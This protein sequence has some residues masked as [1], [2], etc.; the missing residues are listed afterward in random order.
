VR[1]PADDETPY[2]PWHY[3]A[4]G[5]ADGIS[6]IA[7]CGTQVDDVLVCEQSEPIEETGGTAVEGI[8]FLWFDANG[9]PR[10]PK[11]AAPFVPD[12]TLG[13]VYTAG[14]DPYGDRPL[15][16]TAFGFGPDGGISLEFNGYRGDQPTAYRLL[17][18][19]TPDFK[20]YEVMGSSD[21]A[22]EGDA[23][24]WSTTWDGKGLGSAEGTGFY[25]VQAVR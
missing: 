6:G 5:G 9:L 20:T 15:E 13:D 1:S 7:Y 14:V 4:G 17:R 19:T 21:G 16:V 22:F 25:R 23:A 2:G 3:M 10:D 8:A 11:A 18:S 12:Y 24:T